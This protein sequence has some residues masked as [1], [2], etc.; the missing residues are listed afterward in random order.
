MIEE[1][2]HIETERLKLRDF[3][4]SDGFS[5]FYLNLDEE[6]M[7]YTGDIAFSSV[8]KAEV[9]LNNYSDYERNGFGRWTVVRKEDNEILGWCGLK[10]RLDGVIDIGYRFHKK[11][12]NNGYATESASACLKYGFEILNLDEIIGNTDR[13]NIASIKVL[14]KIGLKFRRNDK[15]DGINDSVQYRIF[16]NEFKNL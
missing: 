12:W 6:V 2:F 1:I 7:R 13:E 11:Y 5:F 8:K 4:T 16:R 3:K 14:E 9:F 10:K 15:Y